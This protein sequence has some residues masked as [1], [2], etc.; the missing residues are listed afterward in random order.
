MKY[1]NHLGLQGSHPG[2][3]IAVDSQNPLDLKKKPFCDKEAH[4]QS[5]QSCQPGACKLVGQRQVG[6]HGDHGDLVLDPLR[7]PH[8]RRAAPVPRPWLTYQSLPH[9]HLFLFINMGPKFQASPIL[10]ISAPPQHT[11]ISTQSY[12]RLGYREVSL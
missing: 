11:H 4:L 12:L 6:V 9:S 10:S 7:P 1:P 3:K 5:M 2:L 8:W